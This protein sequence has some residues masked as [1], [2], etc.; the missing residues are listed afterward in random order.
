MVYVKTHYPGPHLA[1]MQVPNY[2]C[3]PKIKS[4]LE[5]KT[6]E[7]TTFQGKITREKTISQGKKKSSRENH[8]PRKKLK[9]TQFFEKNTT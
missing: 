5:E 6:R 3:I 7:K 8:L 9:R 4:P 2:V 1:S